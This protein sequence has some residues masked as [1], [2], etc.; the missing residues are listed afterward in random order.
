MQWAAQASHGNCSQDRPKSNQNRPKIEPESTKNRP[1]IDPDRSEIEP[2]WVPEAIWAP[3][4][5]REPTW[6]RKPD[7]L[8]PLGPPSWEPKSTKNRS[9]ID[10]KLSKFSDHFVDRFWS[11]LGADLVGFWA[12]KWSQNWSKIGLKSDQEA[13]VKM[14]KNHWFLQCFWASEVLRIDKKSLSRWC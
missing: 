4:W 3:R 11:P 10:P 5:L 7:S 1:Q 9:K 8:D 6:P 13:N 14:L 2:G 12:P